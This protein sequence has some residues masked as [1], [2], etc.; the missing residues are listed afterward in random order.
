MSILFFCQNYSGNNHLGQYDSGCLGICSNLTLLYKQTCLPT[1]TFL[2]GLLFLVLYSKTSHERWPEDG[3]A[4]SHNSVDFKLSLNCI[5]IWN[6]SYCAGWLN[7]VLSS[8]EGVSFRLTAF[9]RSI[10]LGSSLACRRST[11]CYPVLDHLCCCRDNSWFC[12][13]ETDASF[14]KLRWI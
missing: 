5:I 11:W 3:A 13:T 10:K 1:S 2:H 4:V 7:L 9:S 8:N 12:N 6:G 14:E